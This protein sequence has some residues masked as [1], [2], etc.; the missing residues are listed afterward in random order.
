MYQRLSGYRLVENPSSIANRSSDEIWGNYDSPPEHLDNYTSSDFLASTISVSR[1]AKKREQSIKKNCTA[2]IPSK[3]EKNRAIRKKLL[4]QQMLR[5]RK[6]VA[7]QRREESRKALVE[8]QQQKMKQQW[9]TKNHMKQEANHARRR[10]IDQGREDR[11]HGIMVKLMREDEER[12]RQLGES[13]DIEQREKDDAYYTK[14]VKSLREMEEN[15]TASKASDL[16]EGPDKV[17]TELWYRQ[18]RLMKALSDRSLSDI[19]ALLAFSPTILQVRTKKIFEEYGPHQNMQKLLNELIA[20]RITEK[21][22]FAEAGELAKQMS[23]ARIIEHYRRTRANNDSTRRLMRVSSQPVIDRFTISWSAEKPDEDHARTIANRIVSDTMRLAKGVFSRLMQGSSCNLQLLGIGSLDIQAEVQRQRTCSAVSLEGEHVQFS[24]RKME[25]ERPLEPG[26]HASYLKP[27]GGRPS[28][29]IPSEE[30]LRRVFVMMPAVSGSSLQ[31]VE[32][33]T[34]QAERQLLQNLQSQG[35]GK[36]P[37]KNMS[38]T[39]SMLAAREQLRNSVMEKLEKLQ[40]AKTD[41]SSESEPLDIYSMSEK[42][43]NHFIKD[44]SKLVSDMVG[45]TLAQARGVLKKAL[46]VTH[47]KL[48]EMLA[49]GTIEPND[50]A[51]VITP[52]KQDDPEDNVDKAP[53]FA[54]TFGG[55]RLTLNSSV[56][57]SSLAAVSVQH[58][59]DRLGHED[60]THAPPVSHMAEFIKSRGSLPAIS[61]APLLGLKMSKR[62]SMPTT[63]PECMDSN[64]MKNRHS[65][66]CVQNPDLQILPEYRD[67]TQR[68]VE[69]VLLDHATFS[70]AHELASPISEECVVIHAE[71]PEEDPEG[72]HEPSETIPPAEVTSEQTEEPAYEPKSKFSKLLAKGGLKLPRDHPR[73]TASM[74]LPKLTALSSSSFGHIPLSHP[75]CSLTASRMVLRCDS[76]P[77]LSL[78]TSTA[79]VSVSIDGHSEL[80]IEHVSEKETPAK[81]DAVES[82]ALGISADHSTSEKQLVVASPDSEAHRA[83]SEELTGTGCVTQQAECGGQ[84]S[85]DETEL[86]VRSPSKTANAAEPADESTA[87]AS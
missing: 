67:K 74:P 48:S 68:Q 82:Q 57:L 73:S 21:F 33:I 8:E 6:I 76:D 37:A 24:D 59:E 23:P 45:S 84:D 25:F 50:Q 72:E 49:Q 35:S 64:T 56:L 78:R 20:D 71:D 30:R 22:F 83:G 81:L 32:E 53:D 16:L 3:E 43:R 38:S 86:Q 85:E 47:G 62:L 58:S 18:E 14:V 70:K 46:S 63:L 7:Q 79:E 55:R 10:I 69:Q 75:T 29:P 9:Q 44:V 41:T 87:E 80:C 2:Y 13:R 27:V 65:F 77:K 28:T 54:P 1:D 40:K 36:D 19:K 5:N 51:M 17:Y 34:V 15:T 66:M 31:L 11:K 12:I 60:H 39:P 4:E 42:E 52:T 26:Q 61:T